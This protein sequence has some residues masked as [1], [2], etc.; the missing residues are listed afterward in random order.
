[1]KV[2][3]WK[4][5]GIAGALV[6]GYAVNSQAVQLKVDDD[7]FANLNYWM[8]IRYVNQK[9][10]TGGDR[11][12]V[13]TVPDARLAIQGQVNDKVEF[14]GQLAGSIKALSNGTVQVKNVSFA[15]GGAN[16]KFNPA[17]QVRLGKIRVPFERENMESTYSA[18]VPTNVNP[19]VNAG[20]VFH[21]KILKGMI[22]Y[23]AGVFNNPNK[24]YKNVIGVIRI[25]FTPV[26]MGFTPE[27]NEDV[28]T[29]KGW[30]RDTYL[31]KKGDI[32][33][34]GVGVKLVP[35]NDT[36]ITVDGLFEKKLAT[37]LLDVEGGVTFVG[38]NVSWYGQGQLL[39]DQTIALGQPGFFAK[40]KHDDTNDS[41]YIGGGV[42]YYIEGNKARL[43]LGL[44]YNDKS[45]EYTGY[46]HAQV[47][48]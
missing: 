9:P 29:I 46:V 27:P 31:G 22:K 30:L 39:L 24:N 37:T 1:M 36:S 18:I 5:L 23:N 15:E 21:G 13:F 11:Q 43:T 32:L 8:K 17:L 12:N 45:E 19:D 6:L 40:Y 16:F 2:A 26:M 41:N 38:D 48:F 7:T 47:M 20:A 34:F 44:D 10:T 28:D 25:D 42:N 3:K 14:Y 35:D 33:T 4:V